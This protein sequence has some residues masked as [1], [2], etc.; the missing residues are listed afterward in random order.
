[1]KRVLILAGLLFAT[2][3]GAQQEDPWSGKATLGYLSTSGN[4]ENSTLNTGFDVG[5]K[6][7]DWQHELTT[8]AINASEDRDTTAEAYELGWKTE[9]NIGPNQFVVGRLHWRK[10]RFSGYDTQF[11]QSLGY[12][13]RLVDTEVHKWN[14]EIGAGARQS[15][16][17]DGTSEE[18]F[19]FRLGTDYTWQISETA[20]FE[21]VVS[22]ESGPENTY[23]ESVSS[24]SASLVGNLALVFSFTVKNNSDVPV[25]TEKTDTFTAISLEYLF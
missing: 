21:Q 7:G 17:T 19:I 16:L 24:V 11:S 22:A 6:T 13:R 18:E 9:Y 20:K 4:T 15:D 5:Y 25:D 8:H 1:M 23:I 2:A 3:A 14:A 12:G 10:D